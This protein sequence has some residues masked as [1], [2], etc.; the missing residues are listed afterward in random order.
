M[1]S[2]FLQAWTVIKS[3]TNRDQMGDLMQGM[4]GFEG[5]AG[6][7]RQPFT[8]MNV[9]QRVPLVGPVD[10]VDE[11]YAERSDHGGNPSFSRRSQEQAG[12]KRNVKQSM[13]GLEGDLDETQLTAEQRAAMAMLPTTGESLTGV[14]AS[15]AKPMT[16]AAVRPDIFQNSEPME[17]AFRLL[18]NYVED[19]GDVATSLEEQQTPPMRF[20][21]MQPTPVPALLQGRETPTNRVHSSGRL[22]VT[23]EDVERMMQE[24]QRGKTPLGQPVPPPTPPQPAPL[25]DEDMAELMRI[26]GQVP[27]PQ[28][29]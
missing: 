21:D 15:G 14:H 24:G 4:K 3:R 7:Q 2:P 25:S 23:R 29:R 13:A 20:S 11:T 10:R 19:Y 5:R 16:M 18:K 27:T 9:R 28:R 26:R 1:T 22:P 8:G 12:M 17:V 6:E